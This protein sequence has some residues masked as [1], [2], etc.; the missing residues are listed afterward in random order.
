[1]HLQCVRRTSPDRLVGGN[2]LAGPSSG[3]GEVIIVSQKYPHANTRKLRTEAVDPDFRSG[4]K[5]GLPFGLRIIERVGHLG[6]ESVLD[7]AMRSRGHSNRGYVG[8]AP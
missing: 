7:D 1:M 5:I 2:S 3:L 8:Y 6:D 4:G